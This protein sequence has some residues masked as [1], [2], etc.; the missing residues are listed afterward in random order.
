MADGEW[1]VLTGE[2]ARERAVSAFHSLLAARNSPLSDCYNLKQSSASA[3]TKSQNLR[4]TLCVKK[5]HRG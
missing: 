1:R 3:E 4:V 5:T 2:R